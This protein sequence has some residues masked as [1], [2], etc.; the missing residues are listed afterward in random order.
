[1]GVRL[2]DATA[3]FLLAP[4]PMPPAPPPSAGYVGSPERTAAA[5]VR[6]PFYDEVAPN[7][8]ERLRPYYRL[9]Y[10]TGDLVSLGRQKGSQLWEVR[11]GL[12]C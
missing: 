5:F 11:C 12:G 10:R 1:M 2:P 8:P 3:M 4:T 7:L 6:N 9:A